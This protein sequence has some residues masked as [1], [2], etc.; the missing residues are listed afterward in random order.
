MICLDS[1]LLPQSKLDIIKPVLVGRYIKYIKKY[2]SWED[3]NVNYQIQSPPI[4]H[5]LSRYKEA[6]V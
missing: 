5:P 6:S 4:T 3:D 1:A 2:E